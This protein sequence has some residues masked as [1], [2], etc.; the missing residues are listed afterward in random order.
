M[1]IKGLSISSILPISVPQ[2]SKG[3]AMGIKRPLVSLDLPISFPPTQ[4]LQVLVDG[5]CLPGVDVLEQVSVG[6][7]SEDGRFICAAAGLCS[8]PTPACPPDGLRNPTVPPHTRGD[9]AFGY[10]GGGGVTGRGEYIESLYGRHYLKQLGLNGLQR[11]A[12]GLNCTSMGVTSC[13][14]NGEGDMASCS[15]RSDDICVPAGQTIRAISHL[16]RPPP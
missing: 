8:A 3:V 6:S 1:G 4:V 16:D 7:G 15:C 2:G 11:R 12:T 9:P 14:L 5:E 13:L 10:G